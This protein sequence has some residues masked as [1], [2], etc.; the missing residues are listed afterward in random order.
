MATVEEATPSPSSVLNSGSDT[1]RPVPHAVRL[2]G[3]KGSLYVLRTALWPSTVVPVCWEPQPPGALDTPPNLAADRATARGA[4]EQTWAANSRLRFIGWGECGPSSRGLRITM[5][6]QRGRTL[7]LGRELDGV[8]D[9]VLFNTWDAAGTCVKNETVAKLWPRARCVRSTAVHEMGHALGFA[10]EQNRPDTPSTCTQPQQGG[11]ADETAGAWDIMSVMNYCNPTRNN[12]GELSATDIEGLHRFYGPAVS[13][14]VPGSPQTG[15]RATPRTTVSLYAAKDGGLYSRFVVDDGEWQPPAR[16]APPGLATPGAPIAAAKRG[17][18]ALDAAVV[19][20][21]GGVWAVA[22]TDDG[23]WTGPDPVGPPGTAPPGA[24]IAMATAGV[25]YGGVDGVGGGRAAAAAALAP[26]P[27]GVFVVSAT[28]SLLVSWSG[29]LGG[30]WGAVTEAT[31][32]GWAPAGAALAA[33]TVV[34]GAAFMPDALTSGGGGGGGSSSVPAAAVDVVAVNPEGALVVARVFA[35]PQ[36]G[37][38]GRAAPNATLTTL[39]NP[40]FAPPGGV[41][42]TGLLPDGRGV[43]LV[44]ASSGALAA[45]TTSVPVEGG[46]AAAATTAPPPAPAALPVS[47]TAGD[48]DDAAASH[49]APVAAAAPAAATATSKNPLPSFTP[50]AWPANLSS[51]YDIMQDAGQVKPG[52]CIGTATRVGDGGELVVVAVT[53]MDTIF[54]STSVRGGDKAWTRPE[55]ITWVGFAP[56]GLP[57]G[58]TAHGRKGQI[59]VITTTATGTHVTWSTGG[60]WAGPVSVSLGES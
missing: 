53:T 13:S 7:G 55:P 41:T 29:G 34:G 10:H 28:G 6:D 58:V 32:P 35:P 25:D 16:I 2:G 23:P 24:G 51:G 33:V 37:V 12:G 43:A 30:G 5:K 3:T 57:L 36:P 42:A 40:G 54:E 52:A 46:V 31:P 22:T 48:D 18:A 44:G 14:P 50:A 45:F 20:V 4:I 17:P 60:P 59:D 21:D 38:E 8:T 27:L 1:H 26:P 49:R 19:G 11:G 9:G 47:G 39:S 56:A 15:A